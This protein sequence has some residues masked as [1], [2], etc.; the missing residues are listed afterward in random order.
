MDFG[1]LQR[2]MA[3]TTQM[4][5]DMDH[6]LSETVVQGSAGGGMVVATM[7]GQKHLIK[8]KIDPT[9]TGLSASDVEMLEDLLT[10]AVNEAER[11]AD[12]ASKKT[13][14]GMMGGVLGGLNLPDIF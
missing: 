6:K 10:V 1:D 14:Q 12:E 4:K 13:M 5:E 9:V 8:L 2:M 3:K 7:N 11:K